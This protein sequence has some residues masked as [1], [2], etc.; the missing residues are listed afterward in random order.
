MHR[1]T[2]ASYNS[3]GFG[4]GKSDYVSC[5]IEKYDFVL[6]QEHWLRESQFHRIKNIHPR[7]GKILAHNVSAMDE[8]LL[9][10]GR[11]YGGCSILGKAP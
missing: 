2:L 3:T 5:L 9:I 8:G 11:G 7:N 1:L 10:N 6:L 4:P